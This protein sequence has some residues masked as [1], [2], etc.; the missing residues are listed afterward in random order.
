[1]F[2]QQLHDF[3]AVGIDIDDHLAR[4]NVQLEQRTHTIG[5]IFADRFVQRSLAVVVDRV[6]IDA[7]QR[8]QQL[9]RT[10]VAVHTCQMQRRRTVLQKGFGD[11]T[12]NIF[13]KKFVE[14]TDPMLVR[15]LPIAP[16]AISISSAS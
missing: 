10:C 12:T 6:L 5:N 15:S 2:I 7:V 13:S 1:M 9:A 16:Q 8:K 14:K 3:F 4:V 11:E